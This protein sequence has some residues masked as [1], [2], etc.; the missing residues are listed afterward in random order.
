MTQRKGVAWA[1]VTQRKGVARAAVTQ[2]KGV[3][4]PKIWQVEPAKNWHGGIGG[5]VVIR[6]G[7][8]DNNDSIILAA[9]F[10]SYHL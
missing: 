8:A 10:D 6:F 2:R 7:I 4:P 1:A 5:V 3:G 9:A